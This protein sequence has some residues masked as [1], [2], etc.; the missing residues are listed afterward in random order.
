MMILSC[1]C[2]LNWVVRATALCAAIFAF[3]ESAGAQVVRCLPV[4]QRTSEIGCWL[5]A[6]QVVGE[7]PAGPISWHLDTYPTRAEA[8]AAKRPGATVVESL[9]KV[10]LLTVA[11]VG[12]RPSGG[13]RAAEIGP[14]PVDASARY[15]AQYLEAIFQ[16]GMKSI[17]HRHGGPEVW[18]T[19]TGETCL[20]TPQGKLV[21]RAGQ[22]VIVP[23]GPPMELTATGTELRRAV[24]LILYDVTQ[25]AST[26]VHDWKPKGL[27]GH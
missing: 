18:Y 15:A 9:G 24:V 25:P 17:V 1:S 6:D 14:L 12:W 23:G 26:L 10:W 2:F 3:S 5:I 8:E 20:E 21:G 19:A 22:P 16:P 27:C 13:E 4:A 7:L 11:E